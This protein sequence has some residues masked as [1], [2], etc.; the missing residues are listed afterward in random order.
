MQKEMRRL[1]SSYSMEIKYDSEK[2]KK[3]AREE[4]PL[5]LHG[6]THFG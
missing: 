4:Q 3:I 6:L 5:L 1:F 2:N